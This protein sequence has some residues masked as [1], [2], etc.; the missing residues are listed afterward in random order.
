MLLLDQQELG[1]EGQEQQEGQEKQE[2]QEQEE[3]E[4]EQEQAARS[5]WVFTW[6]ASRSETQ[7]G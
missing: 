5:R 6:C 4:R 3:Q 7:P 2:E 1:Q